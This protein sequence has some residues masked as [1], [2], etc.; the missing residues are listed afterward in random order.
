MIIT[1]SSQFLYNQLAL[2]RETDCDS[3]SHKPAYPPYTKFF[4]EPRT[5]A[6]AVKCRVRVLDQNKT[7]LAFMRVIPFSPSRGLYNFTYNCAGILLH[8]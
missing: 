2:T 7:E 6:A 1:I 3:Y 8:V 4:I 5:V